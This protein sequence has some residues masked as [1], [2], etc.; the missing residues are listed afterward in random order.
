MLD[1]FVRGSVVRISPEAPVPVLDFE[2]ESFMPG[3]AANVARNLTALQAP[4]ASRIRAWGSAWRSSAGPST[5]RPFGNTVL[6]LIGAL[7]SR[8][9]SRHRPMASKFS[10]ARP[11]GSN[12]M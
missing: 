5:A 11:I 1:H 9:M 12:I 10:I 8:S 2:D 4:T 6:T 7:A 3:G